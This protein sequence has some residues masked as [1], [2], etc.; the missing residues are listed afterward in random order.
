MLTSGR[1]SGKAILSV[2]QSKPNA[3]ELAG[4]AYVGVA[5]ASGTHQ[6]DVY[7]ASDAG[8][9]GQKFA[10]G[11]IA[12]ITDA[13]LRKLAESAPVTKLELD[14]RRYTVLYQNQLPKIALEWANAP[15]AA[16]YA[17]SVSSRDGTKTLTTNLPSYSF[18]PGALA[19]GEH[20]LS[21]QGGG[22][23]SRQ[24]TVHI[25]FDNAAPTASIASPAN[26]SFAPGSN[27]LVSGTAQPGW[28]V[29]VGA[30]TLAQDAQHRFSALVTAPSDR[31]LAIRFTKAQRGVH[32]YLRRSAL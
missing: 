20:V 1:C 23:R 14:G 7:C 10:T 29:T 32:Y 8:G 9:R 25:R 12:V 16:S 24:T 22:M 11:S 18:A 5:L 31:A 13:G 30:E 27:V 2:D 26:G 17:L 4:R 6:Y 28:V 3:T 19:E 15:S 21:F